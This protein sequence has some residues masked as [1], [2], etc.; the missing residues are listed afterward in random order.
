MRSIWNV[1]TSVDWGSTGIDIIKGTVS[2]VTSAVSTLVN[3][4]VNAAGDAPNRAKDKL[5][6]H[7]SSHVFRGEVGATTGRDMAEGIDRSQEIV[8]QGLGELAD[9]PVLDGYTF[10]IPTSVMSLPANTYQTVNDTQSN[11]QG[12][13][14]QLD[15]L[16]AEVKAFH[17]D[18]SS[19]LQ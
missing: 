13:Q 9:R 18:M 15:E 6:I 4:A 1:F 17:E 16:L 19:T 5:G 12:I 11:Q 3:T 14:L 8:N 7:S 2:G 10:D